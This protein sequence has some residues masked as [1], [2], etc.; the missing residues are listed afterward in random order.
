[1]ANTRRDTEERIPTGVSGLDD[2]L[3]GGFLRNRLYLL[4]GDPGTGKTT[5][6]LQYLRACHQRNEAVLYITLS[7]TQEDLAGVAAAHD[8]SLDGITL[9]DLSTSEDS[10]RADAQY[11]IFHPSDVELGET[12]QTILEEVERVK[13]MHVVFDGLSEVRL[14]ARDP[15]RYR[16]QMIALKQYFAEQRITVLLLDDRATPLGDIQPESVVA[17]VII[18]E[19][20][21]PIYGGTRRRLRV[22]KVRGSD[23]RSGY[24]DYEIAQTGVVVHPRLV[25]AEHH[26]LFEADPLLSGLSGLDHML[27]GGLER[28]STTILMGPAGVGKST[29][30][31]HYV[32][33]ALQQGHRAAFYTFDEVLQL[34]VQRTER[35]IGPLGAY[36]DSGQLTVAQIDPAELSP[37]AFAQEV[38]KHVEE[39]GARVVVIDS[40]NGYLSAM[41]EERFL[42][43]HLH[44][45]FA[46]LNQKGVVT[47]VV[48]AQHGLL[49]QSESSLDVSYLADTVLMMRYFEMSGEVRQAISVFKKRSGPHERTLRQLEIQPG[50]IRIGEPLWQFQGIMTGVPQMERFADPMLQGRKQEV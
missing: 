40:L 41:P 8:W 47:L 50:G 7:E 30:S 2:I 24:H 48:M 31:M 38:R 26:A 29:L 32:Y 43:T 12:T 4:K 5:L 44:E 33:A 9:C 18:L 36:Q 17:G 45:L 46:Y 39:E 19:Q 49:G 16:R 42:V 3:H 20:E 22:T 10:L 1:M 14:L 28:G 13:P 23:Y 6:A 35:L 37:G 11:T 27:Q 21:T 15:L 34:L 25:A